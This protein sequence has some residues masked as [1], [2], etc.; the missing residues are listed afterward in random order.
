MSVDCMK[1]CTYFV[2]LILKCPY[3]LVINVQIYLKIIL[4][5]CRTVE[6]PVTY[7]FAQTCMQ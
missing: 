1:G 5:N 3:I 7:C 2:L 6:N 4:Y